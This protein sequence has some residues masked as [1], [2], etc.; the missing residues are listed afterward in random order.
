[1]VQ[2]ITHCKDVNT[3]MKSQVKK[4][5]IK[6]YVSYYYKSVENPDI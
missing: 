3:F 1:M 6:I 2:Q 5:L 4:L